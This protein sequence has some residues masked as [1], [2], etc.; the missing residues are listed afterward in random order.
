MVSIITFMKKVLQRLKLIDDF[1]VERGTSGI[2]TYKKWNSGDAVCWGRITQNPS[3]GAIASIALPTFFVKKRPHVFIS[4]N[5]N[6]TDGVG[7]GQVQS[8]GK[9][10]GLTDTPPFGFHIYLR[11]QTGGV[12]ATSNS[13]G[14]DVYVIGTWK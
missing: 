5:Y 4:Y 3:S 2:W 6:G 7:F 8:Y 12:Q 1:V 13:G 9:N 11:R 10:Y 14:T